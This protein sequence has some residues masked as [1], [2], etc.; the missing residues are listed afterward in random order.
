MKEAGM[1]AARQRIWVTRASPTATACAHGPAPRHR[2]PQISESLRPPRDR[3]ASGHRG[4][5]TGRRLRCRCARGARRRGF[6][7]FS[8]Y[9]SLLPAL[10]RW[11]AAAAPGWRRCRC[12]ARCAQRTYMPAAARVK[13]FLNSPRSVT[14]PVKA[15]HLRSE[16]S[17]LPSTGYGVRLIEHQRHLGCT[18]RDALQRAGFQI[19]AAARLKLGGRLG[20]VRIDG[21]ELLDVRH[22]GGVVLHDQ[23]TLADERRA[24]HAADRRTDGRVI[25]VEFCTR[26]LGLSG[27]D[28]SGL[29]DV[30]SPARLRSRPA[31]PPVW[32][33][34]TPCAAPAAWPARQR[35]RLWQERLR[36]PA[37]RPRTVSDRSDRARRPAFTR[38]PVRTDARPRCPRHAYARRRRA[39]AQCGRAVRE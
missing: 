11:T 17:S 22:A 8:T 21:V 27:G 25:E 34:A 4:P 19:P 13:G 15:S 7:L 3:R 36:P 9:T 12:P 32:R 29:P 1:N 31:K 37:D 10:L 6:S 20:E 33:S 28:V 23:R 39:P 38:C 35:L 14:C 26:D 30:R 18:G 16:N 24:D 2:L 5:A